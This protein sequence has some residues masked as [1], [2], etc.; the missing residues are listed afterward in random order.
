MARKKLLSFRHEE[1]VVTVFKDTRSEA[2][3]R[4]QTTCIHEVDERSAGGR[5]PKSETGTDG[6]VN[7]LDSRTP[8]SRG[9][10][11]AL[12]GKCESW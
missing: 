5:A 11:V 9:V 12:P 4:G 10:A 1:F 8:L 3:I 6:L 7:R 2:C